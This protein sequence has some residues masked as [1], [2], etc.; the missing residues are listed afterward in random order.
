MLS[1]DGT[2]KQCWLTSSGAEQWAAAGVSAQCGDVD[3]EVEKVITAC[4]RK[5]TKTSWGTICHR[6]R[7][8]EGAHDEIE[9]GFFL[10]ATLHF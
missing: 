9:L 6:C 5:P 7:C 10:V 3:D 4:G 8:S 1:T 2:D